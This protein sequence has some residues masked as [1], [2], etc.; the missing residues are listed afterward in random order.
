MK[1]WNIP[2][3]IRYPTF[4]TT[5]RATIRAEEAVTTEGENGEEEGESIDSVV[6]SQIIAEKRLRPTRLNTEDA[7]GAV[8]DVARRPIDAFND[9][10]LDGSDLATTTN[11][12]ENPHIINKPISYT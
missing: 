3:Q 7:I 4:K 12:L 8:R 5:H 6:R 11:R 1:M 2:L 10:R 9:C